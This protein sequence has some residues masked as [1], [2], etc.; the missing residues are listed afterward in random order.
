MG[1]KEG[2]KV[3]YILATRNKLI[4]N[5]YIGRGAEPLH[6]KHIKKIPFGHSILDRK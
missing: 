1:K 3:E 4:D 6:F 5:H 2:T